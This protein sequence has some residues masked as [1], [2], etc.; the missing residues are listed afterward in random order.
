MLRVQ[1]LRGQRGNPKKS[2]SNSS[3][4]S[5]SGA[6]RTYAGSASVLS[7]TPASRRS[8]SDR[9]TIDS[10]PRRRLLQKVDRSFAPGN[11]PAM[12][13][14]AM[15]LSGVLTV[16]VLRVLEVWGCRP[17]P[18]RGSTSRCRALLRPG[19][20]NGG[21][22]QVFGYLVG[23]REPEL[24]HQVDG[25]VV[26]GR[27]LQ[28]QCHR[29][30]HAEVG[31]RAVADPHRHQRV[32]TQLSQR[33]GGIDCRPVSVAHHRRNPRAHPLGHHALGLARVEVGK[34]VGSGPIAEI[35]RRVQLLDHPGEVADA[36][37]LRERD[38]SPVGTQPRDTGAA[39]P[40]ASSE[41]RASMPSAGVMVSRTLPTRAC[42]TP[43]SD[44][45][46]QLIT[47][48]GRPDARRQV[49]SASSQALAQA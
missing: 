22:F 19:A 47:A 7:L 46:P 45:G 25:Q 24:A 48:A 26:Q 36:A 15:A 9:V 34:G 44:H 29:R 6:R 16:L 5:S 8:C 1:H 2:A 37:D 20:N 43:T 39:R 41:S 12:P 13:T 18:Y 4:P 23:A 35:A 3:I 49:T 21:V 30:F 14:T 10:L 32:K 33:Y 28:D 31:P 11:L 40:A 38:Q 27:P 17:P 42:A